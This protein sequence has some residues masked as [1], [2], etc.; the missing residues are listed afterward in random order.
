MHF[1]TLSIIRSLTITAHQHQHQ[2]QQQHQ[3]LMD[4]VEGKP[5]DSAIS[6]WRCMYLSDAITLIACT[7]GCIFI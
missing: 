1:T 6:A 7:S 3:H 2:Q 4:S 5:L